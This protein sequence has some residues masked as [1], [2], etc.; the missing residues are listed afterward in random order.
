MTDPQ[1]ILKSFEVGIQALATSAHRFG[2]RFWLSRLTSHL[3]TP[4]PTS[5]YQ[6]TPLTADVVPELQSPR[7]QRS[8]EATPIGLGTA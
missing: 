8:P 6:S 5:P 3:L 7:E 2:V 4:N 1:E